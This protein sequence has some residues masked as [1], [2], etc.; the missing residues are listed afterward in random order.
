MLSGAVARRYAQALFELAVEVKLLNEFEVQLKALAKAI[1]DNPEIQKVLFHPQISPANK[2][3]LLH[4][5]FEGQ[6]SPQIKNFVNMIIDRRRQNFIVDIYTEYK[7]LADNAH[8]ILEARIKSAVALGEQQQAQLQSNLS[9]LTG[10]S[11]RLVA[12]VDPSLIGGVV[13]KIGDR[14]ID[15]SVAGRL[16]KLRE[17]LV[18]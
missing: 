6:L 18:Q 17:A 9:K 7:Q 14:V 8:N 4:K 1:S 10:K 5:I 12:E 16:A 2:Q 11:I 3:E 15:G 13:V